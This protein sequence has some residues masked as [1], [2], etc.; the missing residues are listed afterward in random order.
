MNA[1]C[2][3]LGHRKR[4]IKAQQPSSAVASMMGPHTILLSRCDRCKDHLTEGYAGEWS[5]A[6]FE[7]T[8]SETREINEALRGL[9]K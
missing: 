7:R 1:I 2:W 5:L 8:E 6:D 3:L 4:P 9:E